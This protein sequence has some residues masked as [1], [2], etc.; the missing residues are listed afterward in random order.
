MEGKRPRDTDRDNEKQRQREL[1]PRLR[2]SD[3]LAL[4]EGGVSPE[5]SQLG[6]SQAAL[7]IWAR[8]G[9]LRGSTGGTSSPTK[10]RHLGPG[11]HAP[12]APPGGLYLTT[13]DLPS[14]GHHRQM[15]TRLTHLPARALWG[16]EV[17]VS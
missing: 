10:P 17:K 6:E 12:P 16:G 1:E 3:E 8:E 14:W 15:A 2:G 5:S 9:D 11:S 13:E 4:P 7:E